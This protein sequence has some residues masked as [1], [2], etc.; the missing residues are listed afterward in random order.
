[1]PILFPI[2]FVDA[3]F[4]IFAI[5]NIGNDKDNGV[6]DGFTIEFIAILNLLALMY[7]LFEGYK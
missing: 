3:L 5:F 7:Y 2:L 1:M 4:I 6:G